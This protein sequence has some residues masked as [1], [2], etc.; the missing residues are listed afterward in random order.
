[1]N[2]LIVIG[3]DEIV[4]NKYIVCIKKAI[5]D[6]YL[7]GYSIIELKS[8]RENI[9]RRIQKLYLKPETIY[10]IPDP[11]E[12]NEYGWAIER[13]FSPILNKILIKKKG[14]I[15]VY[16]ATE[17]KA[18]EGYFNYC[19]RK[20]IPS[21]VEKPIFAPM[22]NGEFVPEL[23]VPTMMEWLDISKKTK[24][25]HSVMT[26]S[27]YHKIYNDIGIEFIK[28][29]MLKTNSPL[30]SLHLRHAGGVWNLSR[31]YSMR[32]DHPY[33][34]GY[35]MLMHGGYHYIDIFTQFLGLN[36]LVYPEVEFE[37]S[38][39]AFSAYP[40][41]QKGRISEQV[42]AMIGDNEK[43]DNTYKYGET[44]ITGAYCL[45][46]KKNG[47]VI[48]LGTIS[49]EQT[50]PSVRKWNEFPQ[51]VYNK[52]GRTSLVE[53]EAQI[54]TLHS[55]NIM[56]YDVPRKGEKEIE[57]IDAKAK[58]LMRS[59]ASLLKDEEY[60]IENTY[61]GLFHSDSNKALMLNWLYNKEEKSLLEHH[62]SVMAV[63]QAIGIAL[64][65]PG[66][67]VTCDIK[68]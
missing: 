46:N 68:I 44:D 18:H 43:I 24:V 40:I 51:D 23:I 14:K 37:F 47:R 10:Y 56:C 35:G 65:K 15:K 42:C 58:V 22:K 32:E 31:E 50:T 55:L 17:L 12:T 53:I 6:N 66:E 13:D 45:K 1:M 62:V 9:D 5:E 67:T 60:I 38:I 34:Y 36:R 28:K 3:F 64:K 39:A 8:Q 16:I 29:R 61:D 33:K 49:L 25:E 30:T 57:R 26:L 20:G 2:H 54:G 4:S 41:D 63:I 21:L 48:T 19:I 11:Q 52:N 59:N 27:R 7:D